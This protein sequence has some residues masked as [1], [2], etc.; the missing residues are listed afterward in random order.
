MQVTNSPDRASEI[1]ELEQHMRQADADWEAADRSMQA[2]MRS[3]AILQ[4][5]LENF[6]LLLILTQDSP[7]GATQALHAQME[8]LE[9]RVAELAEQLAAQHASRDRAEQQFVQARLALAAL[10]RSARQR[11]DGRFAWSKK[12]LAFCVKRPVQG[13]WSFLCRSGAGGEI[14]PNDQALKRHASAGGA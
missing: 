1:A 6:R 12:P 8:R 11:H 9:Q 10:R 2:D 14:M 5:R 3:L 13:L 4:Q 7:T